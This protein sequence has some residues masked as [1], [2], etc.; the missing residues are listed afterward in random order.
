MNKLTKLLITVRG[1]CIESITSTT[2]AVCNV[3]DWD[4]VKQYNEEI[5]E[6]FMEP[7]E[8]MSEKEMY[9][10]ITSLRVDQILNNEI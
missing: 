2:P 9:E 5:S 3:I 8:L 7:V 10:K 1:G 6:E 4:L